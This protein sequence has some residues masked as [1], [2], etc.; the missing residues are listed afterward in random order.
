MRKFSGLMRGIAFI[1]QLGFGLITPPVV[2]V[3]LARWLIDRF[4][5]GNWVMLAAIIVGMITALSSTW[6][7][8][9]KLIPKDK[10]H[11]TVQNK[12]E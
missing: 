2:L 7:T 6:Q 5:W 9:K 11:P 4:G 12:H 10:P 1:G 3:L 8:L